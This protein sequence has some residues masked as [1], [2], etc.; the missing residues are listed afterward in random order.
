MKWTLIFVWMLMSGLVKCQSQDSTPVANV[1]LSFLLVPF[2]PLLTVEV[3]T[4]E[5]VSL[6][7]ESNFSDTHG[8]NVKWYLRETMNESYLF[9]G[10]AE[11]QNELLRKDKAYTHLPYIGY[12]YAKSFESNWVIDG[13]IGI[14][15]TLNADKNSV[16]PV[17][18]LG[19]GKKF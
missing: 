11:I 15:P 8:I 17:I 19:V 2:T 16:Y 5:R 18:K 1:R 7:L 13:R 12:G 14:G 4:I 9:I 10:M 6:Q 3:K